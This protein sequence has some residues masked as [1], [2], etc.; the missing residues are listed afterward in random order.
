MSLITDT[1]D[2]SALLAALKEALD[3]PHNPC[4]DWLNVGRGFVTGAVDRIE[5]LEKG[6]EEWR[7]VYL[8]VQAEARRLAAVNRIA[9]EHLQTVL[10][11][12]RTAGEQQRAG[13]GSHGNN[14]QTCIGWK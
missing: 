3:A 11:K 12:C 2:A 7:Q 8:V 13:D 10:N 5:W 1:G 9:V 6:N 14:R 4:D